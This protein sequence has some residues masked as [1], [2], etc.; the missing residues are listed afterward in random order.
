[1]KHLLVS[2]CFFGL[3]L[4]SHHPTAASDPV[5]RE[6]RFEKVSVDEEKVFFIL[7]G[8]YPPELF[9]LKGENPR[10]VCDFLNTRLGKVTSRLI[11]TKGMLIQSIRV[12]VHASSKPKIRVVLDLSP[13]HNYDIQQRFFQEESIF[14]ITVS[15]VKARR[16]Q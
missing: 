12:G 11:D 15:P 9:A 8:F 10:V 16:K 2:I 14:L 5:L 1:M 6:I 3:M 4:C 13:N 7:N